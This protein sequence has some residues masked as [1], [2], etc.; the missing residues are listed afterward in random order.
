MIERKVASEVERGCVG[1]SGMEAFNID[2]VKGKRNKRRTIRY[3]VLVVGVLVLILVIIFVARG[4]KKS[5]ET[6]QQEQNEASTKIQ[7]A[8]RGQQNRKEY[9]IKIMRF[10]YQD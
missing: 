8:R 9:Q 6:E 4:G 7:A 3:S 1:R 10:Q 5:S 2:A